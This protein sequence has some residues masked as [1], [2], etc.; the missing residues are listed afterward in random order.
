[1]TRG[2]K[3]NFAGRCKIQGWVVQILDGSADCKIRNVGRNRDPRYV[4]RF[5]A[6]FQRQTDVDGLNV[7]FLSAVSHLRNLLC[8]K[9]NVLRPSKLGSNDRQIP[10]RQID[11]NVL[12]SVF[13]TE[14]AAA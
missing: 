10:Y 2:L 11:K 8:L 3:L 14:R 7:Y 4:Q 1:M 13:E 5:V 9:L 12:R 6:F